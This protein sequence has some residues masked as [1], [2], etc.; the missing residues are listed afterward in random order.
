[1][2]TLIIGLLSAGILVAAIMEYRSSR[3][4]AVVTIGDIE[5]PL[6]PPRLRVRNLHGGNVDVFY[7]SGAD[8]TLHL[9]GSVPVLGTLS[10]ALP[11]SSGPVQIVVEAEGSE[12]FTS[13]QIVSGVD[14]DIGL[15]VIWPIGESRVEVSRL[16]VATGLAGS[17]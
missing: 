7:M 17:D 15:D 12:R 13:R 6:L 5:T 8:G 1:M 10:F 3:P 14:A 2:K 11:K 16:Q 4:E 9:L